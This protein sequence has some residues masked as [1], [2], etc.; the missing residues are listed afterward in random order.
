MPTN[1][2]SKHKNF[3]SL[4]GNSLK[5]L[6]AIFMLLDHV[7]YMFF[8]KV[9][10]L[11]IIGRLAYPIF[12]YNISEGCRYTKNKLRYFLM[13]FI[14]GVLCQLVYYLYNGDLYMS[15]LITFSISILLI[16]SLQFAKE[17]LFNKKY[18]V[19]IKILSVVIFLSA[20]AL[21]YYLNQKLE[22]DYGFFGTL[23]P[24]FASLLEKPKSAPFR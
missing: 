15:I 10:I 21:S 8:Y 20:I 3:I 14:L 6:G 13:I 16:Y 22:I 5:I 2:L 9:K 12:A 18:N 11:R 4:S 24:L 7:G 23:T 19:F 17:A 1:T